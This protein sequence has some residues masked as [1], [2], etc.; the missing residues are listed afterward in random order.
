VAA[1]VAASKPAVSTN[2]MPKEEEFTSLFRH[3]WYRRKPNQFKIINLSK[4]GCTQ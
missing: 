1:A 3:A 2:A 4:G